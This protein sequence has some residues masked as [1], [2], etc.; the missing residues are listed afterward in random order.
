MLRLYCCPKNVPAEQKE[1][2]QGQELLNFYTQRLI[3]LH[4]AISHYAIMK[5]FVS[6]SFYLLLFS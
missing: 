6:S 3:A 2:V 4:D 5:Q 1:C